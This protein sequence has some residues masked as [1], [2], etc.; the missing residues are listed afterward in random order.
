MAIKQINLKLKL[1]KFKKI[2]TLNLFEVY[3]VIVTHLKKEWGE[4]ECVLGK[5][6]SIRAD[7]GK[8][9]RKLSEFMDTKSL[10]DNCYFN[11][12]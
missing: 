7:K 12:I 5:E 9:T 3:E 11:I 1:K 6:N 10:S 4:T 2:K 8:R